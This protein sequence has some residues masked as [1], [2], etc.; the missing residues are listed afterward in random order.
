M[1][2][3]QPQPTTTTRHELIIWQYT[4]QR[5]M[6][7]LHNNI[8]KTYVVII[9]NTGLACKVATFLALVTTKAWHS[10]YNYG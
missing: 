3:F 8:K 6:L 10:R 7:T 4:N 9:V 2:S 1:H 5:S